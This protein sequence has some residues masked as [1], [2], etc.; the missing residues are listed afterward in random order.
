MIKFKTRFDEVT[1]QH[2]ESISMNPSA[3]IHM[4]QYINS[5][6]EEALIVSLG[7][8]HGIERMRSLLS[9]NQISHISLAT[10]GF[11]FEHYRFHWCQ[12]V[13]QGGRRVGCLAGGSYS[14]LPF[15]R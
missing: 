13:S 5:E 9:K 14:R 15:F 4:L 11:P 2:S 10:K 12:L 1:P 8:M 6:V 3:L 7:K